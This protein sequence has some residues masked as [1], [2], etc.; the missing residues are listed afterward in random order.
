MT[1]ASPAIQSFLTQTPP[2]DRLSKVALD[3]LTSRIG[4]LRY[5]MGQAIILNTDIPAH[6][7]IIY[8]GQVRILGSSV[9]TK[10]PETLQ[11]LSSG[12]ILGWQSIL[13]EVPCETA[14]ASVESTCLA[15]PAREFRQLLQ[16]EPAFAAAFHEQC[17]LSELYDLLYNWTL[18]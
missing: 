16:T 12:A 11:R 1:T 6:V 4:Q 17:G 18:D 5:R 2:F 8:D 9:Q 7:F 13:R 15:L 14:I 3:Q 10:L